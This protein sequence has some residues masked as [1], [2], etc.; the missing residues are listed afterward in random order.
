VRSGLVTVGVSA[1]DIPDMLEQADPNAVEWASQRAAGLI[2]KGTQSK[3]AI[4]ETTRAELRD[5]VTIAVDDGWS[6]QMLAKEIEDGWVFSASRASTV[7]RT[8]LAAAHVQGNLEGWRQSGVVEKKQSILGSEHDVDDIC[9]MAAEDG[10]I[11]LDETFSN[12]EDGPPYH[13]NCVCDLVAIT[14]KE[15]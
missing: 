9:D 10:P 4:T 1:D 7:A 11:G 8:E 12:G 13:P 15:D 2:G 3:Y 14:S 5:L 6:S